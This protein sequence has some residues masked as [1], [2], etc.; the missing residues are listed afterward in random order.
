MITCQQILKALTEYLEGDLPPEEEREF[1][2]HMQDCGS[3]HAFFRT[4][5]KSTELARQTL[6]ENE[7]PKELQARVRNYL[8]KKL[9]LDP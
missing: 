3:C 8:K 7:I 4:Y 9:G 5:E 6:R 2:Q 1:E